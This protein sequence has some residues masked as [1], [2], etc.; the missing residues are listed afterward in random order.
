M[1]SIQ[2]RDYSISMEKVN[3]QGIIFAL[4]AVIIE[5]AGFIL[6][7]GA[8]AFKPVMGVLPLAALVIAGNIFHEVFHG[9]FWATLG[10][11]R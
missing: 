1:T 2:K 7:Y 8:R 4:P 6:I 10:K 5:L 3:L 9:T 11:S